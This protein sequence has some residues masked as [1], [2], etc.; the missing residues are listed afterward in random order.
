MW[1][2]AAFAALPMRA[3]AAEKTPANQP[4]ILVLGDSL[5]AGY[6]LDA[7]V[8]WVSLLQ[9]KLK[10]E[11][12]PHRVAN[13][14][15]SGDTTSGGLARLPAALD[16]NQPQIVLIELGGNDGLRGLPLKAMRENLS[17]LVDKARAGGAQVLLFEIMIPP[18]YGAAYTKGF[19]DSFKQV[20]EAKQVPLVPFFLLPLVGKDG[21]F[22]DDGIHPSA[23]SQPLML[24]A[25]WPR[26][27]PLLKTLNP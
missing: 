8:G 23:A 11:G 5:S 25:V 16:R 10:A 19:S 7:Q 18:N 17:T 9:S 22:Q 20:A 27:E 3:V 6:G 1:C 21:A 2:G 26:L 4:T 24:E 12:F 13:A 15:I 14:S